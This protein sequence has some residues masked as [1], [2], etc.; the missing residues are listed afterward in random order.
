MN[1]LKIKNNGQIE[2]EAIT[3]LGA[4]TK[5]VDNTKIGY[6]G[7]GNKFALAYLM[8]NGYEVSIYSGEKEFK[9]TTKPVSLGK[10]EFQ[11]ICINDTT[12][13]ITT[14][15]GAKWELWQALREIYSN[16][17]D[18]GG[19]SV[20]LVDDI[21]PKQGETHFYIKA[22]PEIT[23]WVGKFNNYFSFKKEV[24]FENQ[25]GRILAKHNES[26]NFYR[27][28]IKVFEP[29]TMSIYDYDVNNID[30][31]EDRMVRYSFDVS[32]KIWNLLFTCTD[33][34]IILNVLKKSGQS[35]WA[36]SAISEYA[37]INSTLISNEFK[38]CINELKVCSRDM[39]GW[40]DKDEQLNTTLLNPILFNNIKHIVEDQNLGKKFR[41]GRKG[42]MWRVT[43]G[44][45]LHQATLSKAIDFLN[46]VKYPI[47]EDYEIH[48]AIF[49]EPKILGYA[50][51]E[52]NA[53]VL[54][55]ICLDSGVNLAVETI[56]EE[57]I[58]LKY[59]VYDETR[60]FQ[61]VIIREMVKVLKINN[62]YLI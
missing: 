32:E 17:I 53:I 56:I 34:E 2:I 62:S 28:G 12:T 39:A 35:Q 44:N 41:V 58:H 48:I 25:H 49:N 1:Y 19:G 54:S 59:E 57:Y 33:K 22:K 8:R 51:I 15:F 36:E 52:K 24:L 13:S 31:N 45:E 55:E 4:S 6:F 3:L 29:N 38:E 61:D 50:D 20:T 10:D 60:A 43:G 9:I 14:E 23:E 40:L 21:E 18:E 37:S 26:F 46:E 42:I 5:R 16:A 7:S 27:L 11:V 30:I 47:H